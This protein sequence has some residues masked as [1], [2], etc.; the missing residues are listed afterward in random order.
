MQCWTQVHLH[1]VSL[2]LCC[3]AHGLER[4]LVDVSIHWFVLGCQAPHGYAMFAVFLNKSDEG[5]I[6]LDTYVEYT[7]FFLDYQT[8]IHVMHG[9][10]KNLSCKYGKWAQVVQTFH[11]FLVSQSRC[12]HNETSSSLYT[13]TN[14]ESTGTAPFSRM[15]S[16][17]IASNSAR[18]VSSCTTLTWL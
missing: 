17:F 15:F 16:I 18:G 1:K 7:E 11:L 12:I 8:T 6:R 10:K 4:K 5:N 9:A 14:S 13:T 3:P 2:H